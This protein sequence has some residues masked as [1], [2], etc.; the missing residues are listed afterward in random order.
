MKMLWWILF[1][2][3]GALNAYAAYA[4]GL[5]GIGAYLRGLG[6]WGIVATA[7]LLTALLVGIVWQWRDARAKGVAALPYA[8]VT[9]GTGSLGLLLYLIRHDDPARKS[10]GK[11]TQDVMRQGLR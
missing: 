7:D 9:L 3:F 2:S 6:P 8:L 5:R 4:A 11:L 1:A 10:A